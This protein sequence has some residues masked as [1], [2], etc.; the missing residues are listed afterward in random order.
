MRVRI[1]G[2]LRNCSPKKSTRRTRVT[3]TNWTATAC[4]TSPK[5]IS[6]LR[7]VETIRSSV[8]LAVSKKRP[9]AEA[10]SLRGDFSGA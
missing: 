9:G 1:M 8:N 10:L 4:G 7:M 6:S 3:V 5:K 2:G